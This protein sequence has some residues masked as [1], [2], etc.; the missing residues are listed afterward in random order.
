MSMRFGSVLLLIQ[1]LRG[2]SRV[3]AAG[4]L[5]SSPGLTDFFVVVG[6]FF[7]VSFFGGVRTLLCAASHSSSCL[8]LMQVRC[9]V[10]EVSRFCVFFCFLF[11]A[12]GFVRSCSVLDS[13]MRP[14]ALAVGQS[15]SR[16]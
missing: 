13:R 11:N 14:W 12:V 16:R 7:F 3:P 1:G 2:G 5:A 10:R 4:D 6:S 15:R 9:L 8:A